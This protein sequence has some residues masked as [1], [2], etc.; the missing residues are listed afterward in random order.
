M[1]GKFNINSGSGLIGQDVSKRVT[2]LG[3]SRH[4]GD[5]IERAHGHF[6]GSRFDSYHL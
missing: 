2:A 6:A 1:T 4:V 3:M 5:N